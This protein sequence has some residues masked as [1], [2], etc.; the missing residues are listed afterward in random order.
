VDSKGRVLDLKF[1]ENNH[2]YDGGEA[3]CV[4]HVSY[5]YRKNQV[6]EICYEGNDSLYGGFETGTP[7]LRTYTLDSS[8]FIAKVISKVYVPRKAYEF[9]RKEFSEQDIRARIADSERRFNNSAKFIWH[10]VY[11]K[12]K[13]TGRMPTVR[14]YDYR[15]DTRWLCPADTLLKGH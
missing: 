13:L 6:V 14:G 1:M 4:Y 9:Y 11:S 12:A 5:A 3:G 2:V 15:S 7:A 10:Y 8:G